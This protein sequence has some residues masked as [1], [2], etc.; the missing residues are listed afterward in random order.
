MKILALDFG[1]DWRG[2]QRQTFLVSKELHDRRVDICLG[3][4]RDSALLERA[5]SVPGLRVFP[6]RSGSETAPGVILD[7]AALVRKIRP[8][9]V[10]S[11]DS[12]SHGACV[13]GRSHQHAALT[14]HRRVIFPPR[15][16]LLSRLKYNA[17]RRFLAVSHN[18]AAVLIESGIPEGKIRV[19]PDGLPPESYVDVPPALSPPYRLVHVGAFDGRKGQA[20]AV[21]ILAAL[22]GRGKDVVLTLLGEGAERPA[23]E[24]LARKLGVASRCTFRGLVPD[25][26]RE[27]SQAHLLLLPSDS[28][29][30]ATILTEAMAAGCPV[31]AHD[32]GGVRETVCDGRS[33][34]LVAGLRLPDWEEAVGSLLDS[35]GERE[36]LIEAGRQTASSRTIANT[37]DILLHE[38]RQLSGSHTEPL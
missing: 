30:A 31:I 9:V 26:P 6:I 32:V 22:A 38:F 20:L 16:N 3:A 25:V 27:L 7:T 18:A 12:T 15:Q 37:A 36:S 11:N 8:D 28:E 34:R 10:W 14:V 29:G 23:I 17:V 24:D 2:G 1:E 4:F 35:S 21:E 5:C 33:G 13:W 19:V